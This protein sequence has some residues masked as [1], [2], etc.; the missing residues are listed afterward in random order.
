MTTDL[1]WPR[2]P[3]LLERHF[4]WLV[5]EACVFAECNESERGVGRHKDVDKPRDGLPTFLVYPSPLPYYGPPPFWRVFV[6]GSQ[7]KIPWEEKWE[8]K[9]IEMKTYLRASSSKVISFICSR[10]AFFFAAIALWDWV[11]SA[12]LLGIRWNGNAESS[13]RIFPI[14]EG[15]I[16]INGSKQ[17]GERSLREYLYHGI[18]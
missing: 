8:R 16:C 2:R 10:L 5:H 9:R 18:L 17:I 6:C 13:M 12:M 4:Q 11:S 3:F 1:L 14:G 15:V 7:S